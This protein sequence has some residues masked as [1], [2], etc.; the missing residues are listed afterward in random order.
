MKRRCVLRPQAD[1]DIDN[2]AEFIARTDVKAGLQFLD[3]VFGTFESLAETPSLGSP[4]EFPSPRYEKLR[5]WPVRKFK[6]H[7]VFFQP[8]SD[9]IE[10]VRVLHG[11]QDYWTIL[12]D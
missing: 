6:N 3:E 11:S 8:L 2:L 9:G 7:F 4:C 10:V 12:G 1:L 5:F